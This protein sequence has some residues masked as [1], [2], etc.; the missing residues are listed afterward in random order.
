MIRSHTLSNFL[1]M[2]IFSLSPTTLHFYPLMEGFS[3]AYFLGFK[4]QQQYHPI[5]GL[6]NIIK[7]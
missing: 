7:L 2:T 6:D 4:F 3:Y 1:I 5:L